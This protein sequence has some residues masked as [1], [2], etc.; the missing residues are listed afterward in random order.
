MP[1]YKTENL[2]SE[3][4]EFIWSELNR[5][6]N[7]VASAKVSG[8]QEYPEQFSLINITLHWFGVAQKC[9]S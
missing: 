8:H 3:K 6:G 4:Q 9:L 1:E 5:S 7:Q 2:D